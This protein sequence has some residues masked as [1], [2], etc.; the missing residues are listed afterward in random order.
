V[1]VENV[2]L[3]HDAVT[4]VAVVGRPD[5]RGLMRPVAVAVAVDGADTDVATKEIHAS[6][7]HELGTHAAP[8]VEW[9]DSLP[10]LASGKVNRR[11]LKEG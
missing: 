11:A 9:R 3:S 4:D 10:R 2:V 6:V 7:A 5:D 8:V 1:A